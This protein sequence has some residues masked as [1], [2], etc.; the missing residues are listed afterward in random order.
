MTVPDVVG[1]SIDDA[2]RALEAQGLKLGAQTP[3]TSDEPED[4]VLA[5]DP[6]ADTQLAV[7][8]AVTVTVSAG[9]ATVA[10]P[11]F[12]VP[13]RVRVS[14]VPW[15]WM[16]VSAAMFAPTVFPAVAVAFVPRTTK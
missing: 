12:V 13:A 5:Q 10:S 8:E 1:V 11:E 2:Q 3:Q 16:S 7:G 15:I 9:T 14:A 6:E 4:T